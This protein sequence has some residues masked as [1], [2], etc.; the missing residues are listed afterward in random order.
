MHSSHIYRVT[1]LQNSWVSPQFPAHINQCL[2]TRGGRTCPV[3]ADHFYQAYG[4]LCTHA[5]IEETLLHISACASPVTLRAPRQPQF[6]TETKYGGTSSSSCSRYHAYNSE[7]VFR[8]RSSLRAPAMS[9]TRYVPPG[10]IWSLAP[11]ERS[12]SLRAFDDNDS[13]DYVM[14][15]NS[16]S[17]SCDVLGARFAY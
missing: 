12:L 14:H 16:T 13:L 7:E 1:I 9:R 4:Q 11:W 10:Q 8:I 2:Q 5:Y 15:I 6:T 17:C 3:E